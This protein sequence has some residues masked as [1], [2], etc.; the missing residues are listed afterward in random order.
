MSCG[1]EIQSA[2]TLFDCTGLRVLRSTAEVSIFQVTVTMSSTGKAAVVGF[3]RS[4]AAYYAPGDIRVNVIAPALVETPMS[5][6]AANDEKIRRFVKSKQPLDGGRIGAP[7][8]LDAAAVWLLSE[9]AKFC[10]GQV[11]AV[12]GGWCVSQGRDE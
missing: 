2:E 12:D 4:I 1:A 3:S 10:T 11:I 6:R 5:R 9:G 7:E 8:D